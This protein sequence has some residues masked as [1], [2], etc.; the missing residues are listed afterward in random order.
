MYISRL[1]ANDSCG[2]AMNISIGLTQNLVS[3]LDS[4]VKDGLYKSRSEVVRAAIRELMRQDMLREMPQ[5][6]FKPEDFE[7]LRTKAADELFAKKYKRF[8]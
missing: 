5:K 2:T 8:D 3:Y 7:Q 4:K 6:G 1:I